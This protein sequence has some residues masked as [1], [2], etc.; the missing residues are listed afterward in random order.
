MSSAC[1]FT[2]ADG[3]VGKRSVL[4]VSEAEC[5]L[6][7]SH[8]IPTLDLGLPGD[9]RLRNSQGIADSR[10]T[11]GQSE[12]L[13]VSGSFGPDR[14][15]VSTSTQTI[16]VCFRRPATHPDT[17]ARVNGSSS[18]QSPVMIALDVSPPHT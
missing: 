8:L 5:A 9:S 16:V 15:T 4:F 10:F 12:W 6:G 14:R 18:H 3:P 1:G 17:L 2:G 13:P 11:W 7:M